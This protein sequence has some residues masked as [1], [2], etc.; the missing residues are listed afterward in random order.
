MNLCMLKM[1]EGQ[2]GVAGVHNCCLVERV[3]TKGI[4]LRST[5]KQAQ[6]RS[7]F[8]YLFL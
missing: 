4:T 3:A 1:L 2:G 7:Y 5:E 6:P 8:S